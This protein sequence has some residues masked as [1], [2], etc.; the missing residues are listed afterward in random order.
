M[1]QLILVRHGQAS[2][3]SDDYDRLSSLGEEQSRLLG[4]YWVNRNVTFDALFTGPRVRQVNTGKIVCE[5]YASA[6]IALPELIQLDEFDEYDADG[7]MNR[8][9]PQIVEADARAKALHDAFRNAET[10]QERRKGFQRIFEIVTAKWVNGEALSPD[11][12]SFR[13][14]HARVQR[15]LEK[16]KNEAGSGSRV[17]VFSSGGAISVSVQLATKAPEHVTLEFNWRIRNCAVTEIIFSQSKFS[18]DSFN[19]IPHL[20]DPRLHTFR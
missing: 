12:E 19:T 4:A 6:G 17:A 16:V 11:V 2:F 5:Q 13:E 7:I 10:D 1:S 9:L 18:L 15:G 14:F 20:D 8:L 3:L